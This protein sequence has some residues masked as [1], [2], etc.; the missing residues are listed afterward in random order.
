[1]I[2]LGSFWVAAAPAAQSAEISPLIHV[3]QNNWPLTQVQITT[4]TAE[5]AK[6]PTPTYLYF[7]ANFDDLHKW[8]STL[9]TQHTLI[10]FTGQGTDF[11]DL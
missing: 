7:G 9:P 11:K 5:L 6:S 10:M 2:L 4:L 8:E 3:D 1:M